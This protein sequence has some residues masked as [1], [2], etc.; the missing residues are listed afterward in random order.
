[1]V[2]AAGFAGAYRD[3][4]S[5]R[6]DIG[7]PIASAESVMGVTLAV[8]ARQPNSSRAAFGRE[9]ERRA[10]TAT[11]QPFF[12]NNS[13]SEGVWHVSSGE[14]VGSR[15]SL[16][17]KLPPSSSAALANE[18]H[19]TP[20]WSYGA[21]DAATAGGAPRDIHLTHASHCRGGGYAMLLRGAD[22]HAAVAE[23]LGAPT[24]GRAEPGWSTGVL[25]GVD[26]GLAGTIHAGALKASEH[27]LDA[28]ARA[29]T[30]QL[31]YVRSLHA[32]NAGV[33][34][35]VRLPSGA[36]GHGAGRAHANRTEE[37][38][39]AMLDTPYSVLSSAQR[40]VYGS[41][42]VHASVAQRKLRAA[43]AVG[44]PPPPP[45]P[46]LSPALGHGRPRPT[47]RLGH[48]PSAGGPPPGRGRTALRVGP[49]SVSLGDVRPM[50][51][52]GRLGAPLSTMRAVPASGERAPPST[53]TALDEPE[54]P[55]S[56]A[57]AASAPTFSAAP[58]EKDAHRARVFRQT[59]SV[60]DS[61]GAPS[62]V[63]VAVVRAPPTYSLVRELASRAGPLQKADR[64]KFE[65]LQASVERRRENR[66]STAHHSGDNAKMIDLSDRRRNPFAG[67]LPSRRCTASR[68]R[69]ALFYPMEDPTT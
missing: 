7:K 21:R 20:L 66:Q 54:H 28:A 3:G 1:M 69:T 16:P 5:C 4:S 36:W 57:S 44:G 11:G 31:A 40:R 38:F 37:D 8:G 43:R 2:E 35:Q 42:A 15:P 49:K 13:T 62:T 19:G 50:T 41:E 30:A 25:Q 52:D 46:V 65:R 12:Y 6:E 22:S 32:A 60:V 48:A 47:A 34:G 53:A 27:N 67:T 64:L 23:A 55:L 9:W 18:W 39:R 56:P 58:I 63:A 59:R 14:E 10:D 33:A 61:V 51:S 24:G 68:G 45:S 29:Q 26:S 17:A